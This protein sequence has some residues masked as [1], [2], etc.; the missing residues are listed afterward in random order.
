MSGRTLAVV[1]PTYEHRA[2]FRSIGARWERS[3]RVWAIR[4]E[5]RDMVATWD[6]AFDFVALGQAEMDQAYLEMARG[7]W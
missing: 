2:L 4:S 6:S 1:G 5:Q 7:D 3:A